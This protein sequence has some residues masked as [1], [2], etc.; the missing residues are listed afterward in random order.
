MCVCVRETKRKREREKWKH[1]LHSQK[2][3]KVPLHLL[4]CDSHCG[5]ASL[6]HVCKVMLPFPLLSSSSFPT[7]AFAYNEEKLGCL[8]IGIF[9]FGVAS[10]APM[11]LS[12]FTYTLA[13][14][15]H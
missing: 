8:L 6:A 2:L 1:P 5:N 9:L 15:L 13:M 10:D 3:C 11:L 14:I 7:S 12:S 4:H